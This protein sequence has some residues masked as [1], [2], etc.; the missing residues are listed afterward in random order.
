[1]I[2]N[3]KFRRSIGTPAI[4]NFHNSKQKQKNA[5]AKIPN[6]LKWK[7]QEFRRAKPLPTSDKGFVE[8]GHYE[9]VD[10]GDESARKT[11]EKKEKNSNEGLSGG[12]W[13]R[14]PEK[15]EIGKGRALET[16]RK[17]DIEGRLSVVEHLRQIN[18]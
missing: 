7:S 8:N 18:I 12:S 2:R 5:T 15:L 4:I 17:A 16:W 11:D 10:T 9:T 1:M 14:G 13:E 6:Q 3:Q